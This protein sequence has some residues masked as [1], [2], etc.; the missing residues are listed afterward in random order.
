MDALIFDGIVKSR[1]YWF[2][3][4]RAWAGMTKRLKIAIGYK[5]RHT[6][7][8]RYVPFINNWKTVPVDI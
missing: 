7:P 6:R 2:S 3:W 5:D 8:G 4:N 1:I